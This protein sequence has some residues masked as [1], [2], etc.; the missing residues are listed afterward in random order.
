MSVIK[1]EYPYPYK[2][3]MYRGN[4]W[5]KQ[6]LIKDGGVAVNITGDTFTLVVR[7]AAT[8]EVAAQ[9]TSGSGLSSPAT[10]LLNI[11]FSATQTHAMPTTRLEYELRWDRANGEKISLLA[12]AVEVK[13][14]VI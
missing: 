12:G 7:N 4:T 14:K 5:N 2:I 1:A 13:G 11:A 6:L 3:A 10:G 8:G 9:L